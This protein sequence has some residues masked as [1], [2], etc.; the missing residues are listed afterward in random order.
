MRRP[1]S[2]RDVLKL[3][4]LAPLLGA[5][6]Y[7]V[8]GASQNAAPPNRPNVLVIVFDTLSA[9]HLSLYGYPRETAPNLTRFAERAT[10]FHRHYAGG[11]FTSPGT[12]S[13]LTGSYPWTQRGFNFQGTVTKEY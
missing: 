9:K 11:N 5:A 2:R 8:R 12:S 6:P 7:V 4:A 13:L 3:A 1:F 10:V